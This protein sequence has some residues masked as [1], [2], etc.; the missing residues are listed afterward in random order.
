MQVGWWAKL[1]ETGFVAGSDRTEGQRACRKPWGFPS[2]CVDQGES[3]CDK[4]FPKARAP[5]C[6]EADMRLLLGLLG[7]SW[8]QPTALMV[9]S[10]RQ[11]G[12][13][14]AGHCKQSTFTSRCN[15]RAV[16]TVSWEVNVVGQARAA[17]RAFLW[18]QLWETSPLI[19]SFSFLLLR[20]AEQLLCPDR[21][22]RKIIKYL[23]TLT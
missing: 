2:Q 1:N 22:A 23:R 14:R 4:R 6:P 11:P 20:P 21:S 9:E 15:Q 3:L 19:W 18:P 17:T 5:R 8:D 12:T 7:T 13:A 16:F 10:T